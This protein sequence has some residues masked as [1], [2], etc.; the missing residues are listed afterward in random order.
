[1]KSI[2]K[3]ALERYRSY[4]VESEK[5]A[6]TVEKYLRDLRAFAAWIKGAEL[7]K[8]AVLSYKEKITAEYAPASVNSMLSSL[9]SFFDYAGAPELKVKTLKIQRRIFASGERELKKEEYGR[10]LSAAKKKGK[11]LFLLLQTVCSTGIRVSELRY[12]TVSSVKSGR[13]DIRLKG[14]MR[15]ILLP[16]ELCRMLRRYAAERNITEGS[17]FVSRK[18]TPAAR[19]FGGCSKSSAAKRGLNGKK[20]SPTTCAICLPEPSMRRRRISCVLRTFW[21]IPISIRPEFTQW[22]RAKYSAR[23]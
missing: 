1:M 13:A 20:C 23:P 21:D 19:R 17:I 18:G 11:R 15:T 22:N 8:A 3:K 6:A 2:T 10:L 16:D 14:K 5:S 4:L 12:I 9:N 7:C